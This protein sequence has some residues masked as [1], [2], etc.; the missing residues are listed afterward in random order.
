MTDKKKAKKEAEA[1]VRRAIQRSGGPEL[2]AEKLR[3]V[4]EKIARAI[5]PYPP[6]RKDAA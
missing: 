3:Q 4:A 2:D 5:P 6:P 1:L